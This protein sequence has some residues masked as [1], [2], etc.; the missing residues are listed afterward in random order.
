MRA[1]KKSLYKRQLLREEKEINKAKV[2]SEQHGRVA[3]QFCSYPHGGSASATIDGYK[4][5]RLVRPIQ[6]WGSSARHRL[7]TSLL[8]IILFPIK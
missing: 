5:R 6:S 3:R 1:L 2:V 8:P 7:Q 4:I